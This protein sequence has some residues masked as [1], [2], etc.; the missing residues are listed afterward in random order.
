M[1]LT[2]LHL[3]PGLVMYLLLV[4]YV[5]L[6]ALAIAVVF[7]DIEPIAH[8]FI[9]RS[10]PLHGLFHS[11]LGALLIATP[12]LILICRFIEMR[13]DIIVKAFKIVGWN[14]KVRLVPL[15]TTVLSVYL[16]ITSHL[17]LDYWM[18][19]DVPV[20]YP[21]D[22]GNPFQSNVLTGWSHIGL[23]IG[24]IASPLIWLIGD[25]VFKR[26]PFHHFP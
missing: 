18:H 15:R 26:E 19:S 10:G 20:F 9:F 5:D 1:P 13:T 3:I 16:G 24:L 23:F 8:L 17:V 11:L 22:F 25:R 6:L 21:F 7:I 12:V 2:P 14:P 4:P